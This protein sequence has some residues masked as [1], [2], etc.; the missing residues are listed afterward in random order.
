VN[1]FNRSTVDYVG[2]VGGDQ[3]MTVL[4][5]MNDLEA[6]QEEFVKRLAWREDAL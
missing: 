5:D 6:G 3:S 1:E 4:K 2:P